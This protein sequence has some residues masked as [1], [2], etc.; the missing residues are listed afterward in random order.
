MS[1]SCVFCRIVAGEIPAPI[2]AQNDHAAAFRDLAPKAPVH[3]LVVPKRHVASMA[4]CADG[5]ELG[6]VLLLAAE[7]ARR[8]G[9]AETGYRTVINTGA[10]GGQSVFHLHAHV[11]GGREMGWPPG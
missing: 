6:A 8:E 11:M 5:V 4:D 3:V 7:V 1:E 10:D 9:I 2:L